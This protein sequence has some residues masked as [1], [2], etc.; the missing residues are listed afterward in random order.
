MAKISL[1]EL[2]GVC[3]VQ[4]IK[5][6]TCNLAENHKDTDDYQPV[7]LLL[8]LLDQHPDKKTDPN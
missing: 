6:Y 2:D 3:I 8:V 1:L 4:L 5:N 7:K